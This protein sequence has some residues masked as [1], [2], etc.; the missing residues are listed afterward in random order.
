[1]YETLIESTGPKSEVKGRHQIHWLYYEFE[2]TLSYEEI[3]AQKSRSNRSAGEGIRLQGND[4]NLTSGAHMVGRGNQHQ[5][6][7]L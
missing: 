2:A 1:M 4:V 5:L 7:V 3:Q 6:A